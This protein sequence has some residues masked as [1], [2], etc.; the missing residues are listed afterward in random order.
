M[1]L[2]GI[3]RGIPCEISLPTAD[4]RTLQCV[5]VNGSQLEAE[6]ARIVQQKE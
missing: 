5:S 2:D 1:E 3:Y 6:S 4:V